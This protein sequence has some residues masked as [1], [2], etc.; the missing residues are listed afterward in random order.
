MG[1]GLTMRT[2]TFTKEVGK[3]T[4]PMD[5][6]LTITRMAQNMWGD[7]LRISKME[8]ASKLG[9]T[10]PSMKDSTRKAGNMAEANSFGLMAQSMRAHSWRTTYTG[11]AIIRGVTTVS[12]MVSGEEIR[13]TEWVFLLGVMVA[14]MMELMQT[15]RSMATVY[16]S[17]LMAG[18]MMANGKEESNKGLVHT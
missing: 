3:T 15:T 6:V 11:R 9:Q 7:G 16:S 2:A 10:M 13:C 18:Y 12:T 17:G 8:M 5:L 1:G 14:L 4:R